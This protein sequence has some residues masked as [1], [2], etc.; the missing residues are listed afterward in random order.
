MNIG[1][2]LPLPVDHLYHYRVPPKMEVKARIGCRVRVPLQQRTVVG[3]ITEHS[4]P[5]EG[6]PALRDIRAVLD[7]TPAV[8]THQ[9]ALTRWIA[10]YYVCAWGE[11]LRAA[12]PSERHGRQQP[13]K[14]RYLRPTP[15][16]SSPDA[17]KDVLEQLRGPKQKAL[18]R[19][20]ARYLKQGQPLP[21]KALLLIEAEAKATTAQRLIAKGIFEESEEE[22]LRRP[23]YGST[24][25][26]PSKPPIFNAAQARARDRLDAAIRARSFVTFLLHGVTGSGKTE[27]YLAALKTTLD[28]GRTAI[29][30]VPEIAL[31][32][33]TVQRFRA[34]F[35]DRIAV[36]HSRMSYGERYDAWRLLRDG[37]CSVTIGPRSAVLAPLSNLGL[38]VVDEEHD[39]SYKQRDPAPRYHARDVAVV[40]AKM[41]GAVC[42][43]GSA[44]PSLESLHNAQSGKYGLLTM[45]ERVPV[46]GLRAAP[47]PDIHL[48][49]LRSEPRSDGR[50]PA[51]SQP[52]R[53]AITKRLQR[54]EQVI[55]LQNRRGYS[56]IWECQRC[57]WLPECTDCS[58]TLTYHKAKGALRCH[59][60][61]YT[62]RLPPVCPQCTANDFD[63]LG[64]GTQRVQEELGRFFPQAHVLRMDQDTTYRKNAHHTILNKF[65][66]GHADILVGTQMVA[67][68]LDFDRVTLVGVIS[69]DVGM[70]LPDFRAEEHAAQLLLQVSGRAGRRALRGEVMLQTRRPEHPIFDHVREHDY[71]GFALALLEARNQLFYPPFGHLV[72]IEVRGPDEK[73]TADTAKRWKEVAARQLPSELMMLGPEPA[74]IARVKTKWRYHI[75]IKAPRSFRGLSDWL[76]QVSKDFGTAPS[77]Y[78]IAINVDAIGIF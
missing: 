28:Q 19:V 54:K 6:T 40:R 36:L 76:R 51:L 1:V 78:R 47:L 14:E 37:R 10:T 26:A 63:H 59:Y 29:V 66:Q 53:T 18:V 21:R 55:L 72:N 57:G 3:V 8:S 22:V 34:R 32:P 24:A 61:G 50:Q 65:G 70:G 33:Q 35:G 58:V 23:N 15:P 25:A 16:F 30:L 20:C 52:L 7:D 74:F 44:T 17:L 73:R 60:C 49:D 77:G 45:K 46:P 31:T 71:G 69:A 27:V 11:V 2:A 13:K 67:K 75:I 41:S 39:S 68:G 43:L 12:L 64:V 56:P 48:V 9:L 62:R 4:D 38:I 5:P 42:I